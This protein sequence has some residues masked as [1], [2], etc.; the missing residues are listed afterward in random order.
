[1]DPSA[2]MVGNTPSKSLRAIH[3][4][5]M[6]I[7][8]APVYLRCYRQASGL[9]YQAI[10]DLDIRETV[11]VLDQNLRPGYP[12]SSALAMTSFDAIR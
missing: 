11:T 1:M 8:K 12:L 3:R 5:R 10:T 4:L 6:L 2:A 9:R 7:P